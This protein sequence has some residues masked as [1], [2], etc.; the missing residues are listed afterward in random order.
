MQTKALYV[1]ALLISAV[2]HGQ[3]FPNSAPSLWDGATLYRD[4]WGVPHVFAND[5]RSMAFVFGYAQAEDHLEGMLLGYR[6]ANGRAAEVL[7]EPYV[8]SDSFAQVMRYRENAQRAYETADAI[9][10][11]LCEG[12]AQ[13]VNAWILEHP[14][15]TPSWAEPVAPA[16]ILAFMQ[17]YLLS[18]APFDHPEIYH[19]APGTP[20]AN[21]WALAPS[22]TVEGKA[23]L[24]INP[25]QDYDG[26]FKW[27]EAHLVTRDMNMYGATLYGLPV[28]LQ[29]HNEHLGWALSPNEPDI[30]DLYIEYERNILQAANPKS[31]MHKNTYYQQ[32]V[33]FT[34]ADTRT[35]YVWDAGRMTERPLNRLAT[36]HGPVVG[37]YNGRPL[38]YRVGGYRLHGALRQIYDM[39]RATNLS[40]FR[41][42]M[43][44]QQL[45]VFHLVYADTTG[46]IYYRYNA[47]TGW[48]DVSS[49]PLVVQLTT[50]DPKRWHAPVSALDPGIE[51]GP[52]MM[53]NDLPWILN[54]ES[55]YIQ[56]SGT[57]PWRVTEGMSLTESDVPP[58]L[59]MESDSYRAKRLRVLLAQ[60][61]RRFEDHQALL[62]DRVSPLATETVP[63]LLH[64]AEN[65]GAWVQA[66]HP[67][68]W[69]ALDTLR[70][71]DYV[72]DTDS[73]GMTLFHVWWSLLQN[74]GLA[75]TNEGVHALILENTEWVQLQLLNSLTE[76]AR[77]IR[78]EYQT[79]DVPWGRVHLLRRGNREV[80]IGGSLNGQSLFSMGDHHFE[81]GAWRVSQGIGFAMVIQFGQIPKAVSLVPFGTSDVPESPHFADQMNLLLERRM[82]VTRFSRADVEAH[83]ALVR[84]KAISLRPRKSGASFLVQAAQ[85]VTMKLGMAPSL[86]AKLPEG[87]AVFSNYVEPAVEPYNI[88]IVVDMEFSVPASICRPEN[89]SRLAVYGYRPQTGWQYIQNQETDAERRTLWARGYKAQV[90]AVLGPQEYL[91][92]DVQLASYPSYEPQSTTGV[93]Q[94]VDSNENQVLASASSLSDTGLSTIER[95]R[96]A[97]ALPITP[98]VDDAASQNQGAAL[99]H[100]DSN[101]R[102]FGHS[103]VP[104]VP[105][106]WTPDLF[107]PRKNLRPQFDAPNKP[108]GTI[109]QPS[110]RA[111]SKEALPEGVITLA[112]IETKAV[113]V[114]ERPSVDIEPLPEDAAKTTPEQVVVD[115]APKKNDPV[116]DKIPSEKKVDSGLPVITSGSYTRRN[117]R[118]IMSSETP[119]TLK[120]LAEA[121]NP[122]KFYLAPDPNRASLMEIGTSMEL[123]PP[124]YGALFLLKTKQAVRGQVAVLDHPP[125][126][127]PQGLGAF[128][129]VVQVLHNPVNV[130]GSLVINWQV[131]PGLC[132]ADRASDL[133]LY[134]YSTDTGWTPVAGQKIDVGDIRFGALDNSFRTYVILGPA[135][136]RVRTSSGAR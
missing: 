103:V 27:Y 128:T 101:N 91:A 78:N 37:Y 35:L 51:W 31:V 26:I 49:N 77:L 79:L 108:S 130:P 39:A 111:R 10:V 119:R 109:L 72:A 44:R 131:E 54:P 125:A 87:T 58:W 32:N 71:W 118:L 124:I 113:D 133:S 95:T 47:K 36:R 74:Q 97:R 57:P 99:Q 16:D 90:Y 62:F 110:R 2:A 33:S 134:A 61:P 22:N 11:D 117:S 60:G 126:P 102:V 112:P 100:F 106:G 9:T 18:M 105:P 88:P 64:A 7:G 75:D 41:A 127:Y 85:P 84:G 80:A 121:P 55:G 4:E 82:K 21:A 13:G 65:H 86:Q 34:Q 50:A 94:N 30:A 48:K 132:H 123:R 93:S 66:S 45:P 52:D 43:D 104:L 129:P 56:A 14:K 17:Y 25:Q 67:D 89:L 69:V 136:A 1:I 46:N 8:E 120:N 70:A 19:P 107:D 3:F 115:P 23:V 73:V 5:T 96:I 68:I 28:I 114:P 81:R 42:V 135:S 116:P 12:F 92:G 122:Q 59:A 38:A 98:E 53:P 83:A 24:V 76:A 63:Y 6:V 40:S 15:D 29:G 20:A